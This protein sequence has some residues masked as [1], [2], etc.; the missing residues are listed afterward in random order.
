[1]FITT[2][3]SIDQYIHM[4][5]CYSVVFVDTCY[6]RH[7]I[8][9]YRLKSTSLFT[10]YSSYISVLILFVYSYMYICSM[11]VIFLH[12]HSLQCKHTVVAYIYKQGYDARS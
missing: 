12:F 10:S 5:H 7:V 6:T 4:N 8:K 3:N 1:M 9:Q 11:L 2:S